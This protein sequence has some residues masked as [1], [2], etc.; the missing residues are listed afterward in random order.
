VTRDGPRSRPIDPS[1]AVPAIRPARPDELELLPDLEAAADTVFARLGIGPLP[2]PATAG[3]FG[4]ALV[5]LVAGEPP[6]GL[7]RVDDF[8]GDAHLEQLSVHP[9][10]AGQGIGRALLRAGCE[11]AATN[12][13]DEI[14]LATYRDVPWNGPFYASEGFV[15]RDTA[16]DDFL[17]AHGRAAEEPVMSGFGA[18]VLMARRL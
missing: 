10:H 2:G 4:A 5:V 16:V 13:Y 8:D 17:R 12:G 15:V 7:C 1:A 18:R 9:D 6:V 3:E 11:W 14:T